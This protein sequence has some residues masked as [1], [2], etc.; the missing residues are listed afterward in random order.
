MIMQVIV[1][2][3]A[4]VPRQCRG[5][6][7]GA[8]VKRCGDAEVQ[9]SRRG[10]E[11]QMRGAEMQRCRYGGAEVLNRCRCRGAEVQRWYRGAKGRRCRDERWAEVGQSRSRAG[12]EMQWQCRGSSQVIVQ[13]L[14]FY[15]Y[16]QGGGAEAVQCRCRGGAEQKKR[17]SC[18]GA[19]MQ[20]WCAE[21]Q[22]CTD[23]VQ[24][25]GRGADM[26]V[27]RCR[28]AEMQRCRG[29]EVQK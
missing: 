17:C 3:S 18:R 7:A 6:S 26:E 24:K 28:G 22:K 25:C 12:A 29:V 1:Q 8:E 16:R 23:E 15:R 19:A 11:V 13:V 20:R 4:E 5:T 27:Q 21:V 10:A 2:H 9:R 14:N